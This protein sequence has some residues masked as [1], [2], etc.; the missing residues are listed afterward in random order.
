[1]VLKMLV[2]MI[3]IVAL[4]FLFKTK[5]GVCLIVA[6][7]SLLTVHG[8]LIIF[9]YFFI[10]GDDFKGFEADKRNAAESVMLQKNSSKGKPF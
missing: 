9:Y 6:C 10:K 1:M 7:A 4:L 2:L 5:F 3:I 8:Q